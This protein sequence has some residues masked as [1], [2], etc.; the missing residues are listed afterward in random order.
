MLH[1]FG[2]HDPAPPL[3]PIPG[4]QNQEFK[5]FSESQQQDR[6]NYLAEIALLH[7]SNQIIRPSISLDG[8]EARYPLIVSSPAQAPNTPWQ[9]LSVSQPYSPC[10]GLQNTESVQGVKNEVREQYFGP[11]GYERQRMMSENRDHEIFD[12]KAAITQRLPTPVVPDTIPALVAKVTESLASKQTAEPHDDQLL[13]NN[14]PPPEKHPSP[15]DHLGNQTLDVAP[16]TEPKV[17]HE[18]PNTTVPDE[19]DP[20]DAG[21]ENLRNTSL[22]TPTQDDHVI[23]S[24]GDTPDEEIIS[25]KVK[26]IQ[27][28]TTEKP[29]TSLSPYV[30]EIE[31]DKNAA[32]MVE[33]QEQNP[34]VQNTQPFDA[35][36]EVETA[37]KSDVIGKLSRF[38]PSVL[39]SD[40]DNFL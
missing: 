34:I 17:V 1:G 38:Y 4:R 25:T 40:S 15:S 30:V 18:A 32:T 8:P 9:R 24:S 37:L 33:E 31:G 36:N 14:S 16:P 13:N 20:E 11:V 10:P 26:Q 7:G 19:T 23:G 27:T 3:Q 35:D 2:S 5:A 39:C 29:A 21:E 22:P 6:L 12:S 28:I